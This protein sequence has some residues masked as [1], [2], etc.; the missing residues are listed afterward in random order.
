MKIAR[1]G[2]SSRVVAQRASIGGNEALLRP[3]VAEGKPCFLKLSISRS[4]NFTYQVSSSGDWRYRATM[5]TPTLAEAR[6]WVG[7]AIALRL[8]WLGQLGAPVV[9]GLVPPPKIAAHQLR[10]LL[11][12]IVDV[13]FILGVF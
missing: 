6:A 5:R 1:L 8:A 13:R 9:G 2:V 4:T 11:Q 3:V 10:C 12:E 7:E